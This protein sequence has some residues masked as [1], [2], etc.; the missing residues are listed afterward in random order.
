[1]G[2]NVEMLKCFVRVMQSD[3]KEID[4]ILPIMYQESFYSIDEDFL[5]NLGI[6][7]LILDIDG[8]LLPVDDV[9][10]PEELITRIE[11]LR[12]KQ[13]GICLMSNNGEER[14]S[15]VAEELGLADSYLANA[16]KPLPSAFDRALE[17]LDSDKESVAMVG[18]QMMSDIKGANEYGIY[19]ILVR[20]VS[21]HNNIQTGTSR[22]LQNRMEKHL[23]KIN[24]FSSEKYYQNSKGVRK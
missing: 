11:L 7:N 10:V 12:K 2:K 1:M 8:T 23:E 18:D 3:R 13:I 19:S 22:F 14:V 15:P 20:P 4:K 17:I 9:K 16:H 21:S 6:R 5:L 24:L